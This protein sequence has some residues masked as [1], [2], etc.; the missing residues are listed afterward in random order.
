[1]KIIISKEY[2]DVTIQTKGDYNYPYQL[3]SIF[4]TALEIDGY[5]EETIS[6]IFNEE[7]DIKTPKI[8]K[9]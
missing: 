3:R 9:D 6:N 8:E 5:G 7:N 4:K 2:F 1:M